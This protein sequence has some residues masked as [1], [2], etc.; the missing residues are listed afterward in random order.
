MDALMMEARWLNTGDGRIDDDVIVMKVMRYII[1]DLPWPCSMVQR[2]VNEYAVI[3]NFWGHIKK[4][5]SYV[6]SIYR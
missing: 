2:C 4:L 3:F 6:G 1:Y 5:W